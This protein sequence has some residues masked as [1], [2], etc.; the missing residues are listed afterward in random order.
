M[1]ISNWKLA[2][3][4]LSTEVRFHDLGSYW[5][6]ASHWASTHLKK[7]DGLHKGVNTRK[8]VLLEAPAESL[9]ATHFKI[10]N[11]MSQSN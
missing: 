10:L 3:Y 6:E 1:S 5:L 7:G 11:N 8:W 4:K 9:L 2:S